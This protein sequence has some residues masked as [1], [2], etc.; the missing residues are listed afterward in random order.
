MAGARSVL[1]VRAVFVRA[2][3][4]SYYLLDIA[5]A[6]WECTWSWLQPGVAWTRRFLFFPASCDEVF[7][8]D[9]KPLAVLQ[10]DCLVFL[11]AE[12]RSIRVVMDFRRYTSR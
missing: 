12:N 7:I 8:G 9:F 11:R 10:V 2:S 3:E 5:L 4:V 1:S 6:L